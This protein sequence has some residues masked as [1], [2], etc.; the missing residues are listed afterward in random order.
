MAFCSVRERVEFGPGLIL[1]PERFDPR[2]DALADIP[3]SAPLGSIASSFRKTISPKSGSDPEGEYVVL[4]TSNASEGVLV[5]C[6]APVSKS[7]IGSTKKEVPVGSVIIS[8]LRPYLRQVAFVDQ[9][10][11]EPF[12]NPKMVGSTEFFVLV[13]RDEH[14]VAFLVPFLLSAPV[15]EVLSASQEGGHH[16]RFDEQ[17][18]LSL[19]VPAELVAHR[20]ETSADIEGAI[21]AHRSAA[22]VI[23]QHIQEAGNT[24]AGSGGHPD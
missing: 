16:P 5:S 21:A 9:G 2:R 3:Q 14:S 19:P 12:G 8:R 11:C 10:C 1:A 13:S 15:Q 7:A 18:L 4:D 24:L 20:A 22:A 17:T 6:R 23:N